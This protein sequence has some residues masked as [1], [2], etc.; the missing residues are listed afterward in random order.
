MI[1]STV[2]F[3]LYLD[4]LEFDDRDNRHSDKFFSN[5]KYDHFE[6]HGAFHCVLHT[7]FIPYSL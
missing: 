4:D 1:Y 6:C 7:L 5:V 2:E 3:P